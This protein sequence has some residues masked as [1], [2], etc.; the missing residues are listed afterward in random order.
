[1]KLQTRD[2][3]EIEIQERDIITFAGPIF[4]FEEYRRFVFL[5]H[6]EINEHFV[7]LQ[8][9][10]EPELCFILMAPDAVQPGY[11]PKLPDE[12][13][14]LLR[15]G[16]YLYWLMVSLRQPLAQ[17]TVNLKSPIVVNPQKGL[18]AQF[19]LTENLPIRHRLIREEGK[20]C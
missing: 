12:A 8:S 20:E 6:E 5:Y 13:A 11:R 2:F 1:M 3:G 14:G 4:G 17:S 16:E 15:D 7:W 19:L 10:E 18:A 9:L